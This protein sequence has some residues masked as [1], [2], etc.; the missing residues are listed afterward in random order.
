[1][2]KTVYI[3]NAVLIGALLLAALG[4]PAWPM[5]TAAPQS[6]DE[7]T[8]MPPPIIEFAGIARDDAVNDPAV[9]DPDA[10]I[11]D[12][13]GAAGHTHYLQAANTSIALYRKNGLLIDEQNFDTFWTNANTGTVCD[14]VD[15][16]HG[17]PSVI[18]DPVPRRWVVLDVAYLDINNGPYYLCTAITKP[19]PP[20][21]VPAPFFNA[22]PPNDFWVYYAVQTAD[23]QGDELYP[24]MPKL[25]LWNNSYFISA[26]LVDV[27]DSGTNRTNRGVQVWALQRDFMVAG[28]P[29]IGVVTFY[30]PEQLDY[31][32]LVPTNLLGNPAELLYGAPNY[33]ASIEPGR[34]FI[35]KFTVDW[36]NPSAATFGNALQPNYS[37]T[38]DTADIWSVGHVIPQ[39]GTTEQVESHGDRLMTPM[40]YRI[41]DGIPSLWMTHTVAPFQ[42]DDGRTGLRWYEIQFAADG[43]PAFYQNGTF[44][45]PDP[46]TDTAYRW[47]PSLAVDKAGDMAIGYS[48]SDPDNLLYPSIRYA[49]RLRSSYSGQL[50]LGEATL[51]SGTTFQDNINSVIDGPWGRQSHMSIDPLDECVFWYTNMYYDANAAV[52]PNLNWRTRIGWFSLTECR[53]GMTNRV[54]LSTANAQGNAPSGVDFGQ[55]GMD[56]VTISANGRYVAFSSEATNLVSDDTN[57]FRD[58]FIR[59]RDTDGDGIYDEPGYVETRRI[60]PAVGVQPN[61]PSWEVSM[62]YTGRYVVFSSDANNWVTGASDNNGFRDVFVYDRQT[63]VTE[64]VSARDGTSTTFGNARSDQPFISGDGR[65]IAF[66]S[67]ATNLLTTADGNVVADIFVRDR[68]VT[69]RRTY[70]ISILPV[71]LTALTGES[72]TPT[73]SENGVYI[74]FATKD[75]ALGPAIGVADANYIAGVSEGWDVFIAYWP[76][77]IGGGAGNIAAVSTVPG[78]AAMGNRS[79]YTPFI[80]GNAEHVAFVSEAT[81]LDTLGEVNF[82]GDVFVWDN[83]GA[84]PVTQRISLNFF[85]LEANGNSY[86]PSITTDGQYVVFA[87]E[88]SNL[89]SF[90]QDLNGRRDIFL[91]DRSMVSEGIYD[92]GLTQ[93]VSLDTNRTDPN[94]HSFGPMIAPY[95]RHVAYVSAATDLVTNDTNSVWDVFAYDGQRTL[96]I[97]LRIPGNIPGSPGELV[98]VPVIFDPNDQAIDTTA[99]SVD[100]D[101][102]CL[103]FDPTVANPVVFGVPADFVATYSFNAADTDGE[104]DF[105]IYDQ[106]APRTS[107]PAGTLATIRLR[108]RSTCAALPGSTSAA[109]VG[110][111]YNPPPSFGSFGQSVKGVSLDGFVTI[112]EGM[113]GDCNGDGAVNAGDL[114]AFVL[115]F[116][117]GDDV[118]PWNVPFGTFPGNPVG[119]NPNQDEIVD[120]GDLSCTVLIIFGGG[121]AGCAGTAA[122]FQPTAPL[123]DVSL[124]VPDSL[125]ARPGSTVTLPVSLS[126][127]GNAVGSLVFSLDI[128]QTWLS[129]NPAD[130][131]GDGMP[132]A[133]SFILPS[134]FAA[135]VTY[136]AAD[137]DG[138]LD[139][140]VYSLTSPLAEIPDGTFLNVKLTAGSAPGAFL[141][142]VKS[143]D[144]PTASFG[145]L[146]GTSLPGVLQ[147]GSVWISQLVNNLFLPLV[148]R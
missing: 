127:G 91:H 2:K 47:L 136:N 19:L 129:F 72:A 146:S 112:Q 60:T 22:A 37:L 124:N 122:A 145:S 35:W 86:S 52:S 20:P 110:F 107:L 62:N 119:C 25:A 29:T 130:G 80:S 16:H 106:V 65:F 83:S 21:A 115:E 95:G 40:Q 49:G 79:S 108:V 24:D 109:R 27:E 57:N 103:Q 15:A 134:G 89:D 88:A 116:F 58:V 104:I 140:V 85:G 138:E 30:L 46:V 39:L 126:K 77:L 42:P 142:E 92:Y 123:T 139:V 66:R 71:A 26:N 84:L 113:L 96:P 38:T 118:W 67:S 93:R 8:A 81:D 9:T 147:D 56:S 99:F 48:I 117:D 87:S 63:G 36:L 18:Y 78:G 41:V 4:S 133:A 70:R 141:A 148:R 98:S 28:N 121:S 11:P 32:N 64:L 59:D 44:M 131:N 135:G 5:A 53:G 17:Q 55:Y 6:P 61:G 144:D 73:L 14:D 1:M 120:A 128:D 23:Y 125:P 82:D 76:G 111:S 105:T 12:T 97:F 7:M 3:L 114:T 100:Y 69:P 132:D 94:N 74:A 45:G 51:Y 75:I 31:R 102:V 101:E 90:F 34:L 68:A 143:S 10:V 50:P 13:S 33:F 43:T 54:S 137:T